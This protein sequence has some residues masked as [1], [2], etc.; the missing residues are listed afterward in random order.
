MPCKQQSDIPTVYKTHFSASYTS[1][2]KTD[3]V[4]NIIWKSM[5]SKGL[6]AMPVLLKFLVPLAIFLSGSY[7]HAFTS[8]S[9]VAGNKARVNHLIRFEEP[10]SNPT[11]EPSREPIRDP[12][13]DQTTNPRLEWDAELLNILSPKRRKY[14]TIAISITQNT[15][16]TSYMFEAVNG[17]NH[18][19]DKI[20]VE[21]VTFSDERD[22]EILSESP[23]QYNSRSNDSNG[24][25][26]SAERAVSSRREVCF[27]SKISFKQIK[28][29]STHACLVLFSSFY[30]IGADL[31]CRVHPHWVLAISSSKRVRGNAS[32]QSRGLCHEKTSEPAGCIASAQIQT[33]L[34]GLQAGLGLRFA[35]QDGLVIRNLAFGH[36][37]LIEFILAFGRNHKELIEPNDISLSNQLIVEYLKMQYSF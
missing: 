8:L 32:T 26:R 24:L 37:K 12:T 14:S 30:A 28:R 19:H 1:K 7:A 15:S 29:S 13:N 27:H 22:S 5:N 2:S 16:N 36:N 21:R 11:N 35:K 9:P 3:C 34:K 6:N 4:L 33:S 23:V 31:K 17:V 18:D 20:K 25:R 10:M